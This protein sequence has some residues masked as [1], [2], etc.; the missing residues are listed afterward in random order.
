MDKYNASLICVMLID[1]F[2]FLTQPMNEDNLIDDVFHTIEE[3][4]PTGY[5]DYKP[6]AEVLNS[7]FDRLQKKDQEKEDGIAHK[8]W[9]LICVLS[10]NRFAGHSFICLIDYPSR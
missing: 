4:S 1:I 8:V 7:A 10:D 9:K 3:P 6:P 5:R 2:F